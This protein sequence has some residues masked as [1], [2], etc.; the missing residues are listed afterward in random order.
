VLEPAHD[1]LVGGLQRAGV[2]KRVE[3]ER[4]VARADQ[5]DDG[6]YEDLRDIN[7]AAVAVRRTA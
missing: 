1:R 4:D 6:V 7:R 2:G 5:I 3:R